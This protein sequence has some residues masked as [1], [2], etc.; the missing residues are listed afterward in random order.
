M[1]VFSLSV[2]KPAVCSVVYSCRVD[3]GLAR[4]SDCCFGQ[5][6]PCAPSRAP[7][8]WMSGESVW[9]SQVWTDPR[10]PRWQVWS[11]LSVSDVPVGQH[12]AAALP[13]RER[14]E[15]AAV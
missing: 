3:W 10:G 12:V 7:P 11:L 9:Y 15:G 6:T 1:F 14:T 13:W 4:V 2:E 8:S 5:A